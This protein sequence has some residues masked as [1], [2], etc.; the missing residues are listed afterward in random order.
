MT[1]WDGFVQVRPSLFRD[2]AG[3]PWGL[4]VR[5]DDFKANTANSAHRTLVLAGAF[6][7]VAR[8]SSFAITYQDDVGH[9]EIAPIPTKTMWQLN[10]QIT[11]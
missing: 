10:W 1:V 5:Y 6:I 2:P 11:F 7:D 8:N 3:V 9:S 4:I